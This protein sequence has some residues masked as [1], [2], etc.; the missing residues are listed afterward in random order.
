VRSI[1][2]TE[3]LPALIGIELD[4][5]SSERV[6]TRL[7]IHAPLLATAGYLPSATVVALADA[8][9]GYGTLARL[10]EGARP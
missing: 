1:K 4:H 9:C 10:S 5:S 2:P 7:Q 6:T 3:H 8:A